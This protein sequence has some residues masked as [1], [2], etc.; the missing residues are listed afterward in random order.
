MFLPSICDRPIFLL[1]E[2]IYEN[3]RNDKEWLNLLKLMSNNCSKNNRVKEEKSIFFQKLDL[4]MTRLRSNF[5]FRTCIKSIY[6]FVDK[7]NFL[8]KNTT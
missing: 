5:L 8:K 6:N 7:T 2:C 3:G 1:L 4:I